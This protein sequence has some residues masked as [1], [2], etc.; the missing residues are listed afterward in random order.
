MTTPTLPT[1][2]VA[3]RSHHRMHGRLIHRATLRAAAAALLFGMAL[4]LLAQHPAP[5]HT[6]DIHMNTQSALS[7]R[8]QAILPI[9][10]FT[11]AGDLHRLEPALRAALDAGLTINEIK[12]IL[13]QLYA[14]AG[15]PRALNALG[16][17][18]TVVEDRKAQGVHDAQGKAPTALPAPDQMLAVGTANQT[19]LS[20]QPVAGPLFAFSPQIDRYL[21]EHL[22]GAIFARDNLD[23]G[24]R[25]LATVAALSAMTG[26]ESQVQAHMRISRNVAL[27]EA[28]LEHVVAVL[29]DVVS[30]EA[31]DRAD[32]ARRHTLA[33]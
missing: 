5:A 3:A 24:D 25:E 7:A 32:Q 18:M 20:G 10:A 19:R 26:T 30:A 11:A 4:P 33:N 28:Q 16:T 12:E 1:F 23:W 21:K 9:A 14:Y 29:R 27:S 17:F 22:F 13:G 6:T 15:F 2:A 31:A 8:Q